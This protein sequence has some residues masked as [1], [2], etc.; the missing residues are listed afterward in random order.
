M[1]MLTL[2]AHSDKVATIL[3]QIVA[4]HHSDSRTP[5]NSN[6]TDIAESPDE[7]TE[8][9]SSSKRELL[10]KQAHFLAEEVE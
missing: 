4:Q 3:S 10:M 7:D 8:R 1:S 9:L 5:N 2:T 6:L